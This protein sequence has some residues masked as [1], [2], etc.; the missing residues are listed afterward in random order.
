MTII[1]IVLILGSLMLVCIKP[2]SSAGLILLRQDGIREGDFFDY[3]VTGT[4]NNTS[5]T[6]TYHIEMGSGLSWSVWKNMSDPRLNAILDQDIPF[7]FFD[8]S[9]EVGA[10][11][12]LTSYGLKDVVWLFKANQKWVSICYTGTDPAVIYG[13]VVNGQ[14]FHLDIV[15]KDTGNPWAITNNTSTLSLNPESTPDTNRG[16][17]G[18]V[19]NAGVTHMTIFYTEHGGLLR[20]FLNATDVDIL[21]FGDGNIRSMAEGGPYAFD[22][23]LTGAH[24][25]DLSDEMIIPVGFYAITFIG[26]TQYRDQTAHSS[27][28]W[29]LTKY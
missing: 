16:E 26:Q 5:V 19:D 29:I 23:R 18:G 14:D 27:F 9:S 8:S 28:T 13:S 21:A 11:K 17:I 7:G 2:A 12:Y 15:L 24:A 1:I 6:G 4:F 10:G 20:Y 3:D 25:G 22:P